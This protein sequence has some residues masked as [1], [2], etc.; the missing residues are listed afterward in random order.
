MDQPPLP[1]R[2][3]SGRSEA[4][5]PEARGFAPQNPAPAAPGGSW[6]PAYGCPAEGTGGW[7][8]GALGPTYNGAGGVSRCWFNLINKLIKAPVPVWGL[9][10]YAA[11]PNGLGVTIARPRPRRTCF[12]PPPIRARMRGDSPPV[13]GSAPTREN[14]L[15]CRQI[16][17]IA[18]GD[19]Q[20]RSSDSINLPEGGGA[21]SS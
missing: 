4:R 18:G 15:H 10:G 21:S 11:S 3:S 14:R 19:Q 8:S 13:S 5:P 17:Y 1:G 16:R 7:E 20:P 6:P 2:Y 12:R 9:P